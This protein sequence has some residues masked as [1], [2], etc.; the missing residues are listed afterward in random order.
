MAGQA[1]EAISLT[2]WK[3]RISLEIASSGYRP[4]RN[5]RT[6]ENP[7][8]SKSA[9]YYDEIYA[10][11][12]KD[13]S[14]EAIKTHKFIQKYKRSNGNNLLDVACGTG[15]HANLLNRYYHV[16]GLDLDS[17][18][19][20][21]ARRKYPSIKFHQGDMVDFNLNRQFD[22]ITCLFSSI[23]YVQTK[24]RLDKAIKNMAQHLLPGGVLLVEPWFSREQWNAGR[25]SMVS[26]DQPDLKIVRM[27]RASRKGNQS[28]LEFQYLF[29]TAK[30]IEH[31]TEIHE[32]GLFSDKDYLNAFRSAGLKVIHDAKGLDGRGL[33]IGVKPLDK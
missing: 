25:V 12:D 24:S 17:E 2:V 23:G 18:M 10:S 19:I 21:V 8:F 15:R 29:G 6:V 14:A 28:I 9:K 11:V 31:S 20:S 7:M 33:Y 26:V 13:Y 30:G 1:R 22:V 3:L 32:L 27:S 16:A 4:P 5:D